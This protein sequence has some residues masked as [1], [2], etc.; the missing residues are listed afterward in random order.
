MND[1]YVNKTKTARH[2]ILSYVIAVGGFVI[3]LFFG[4]FFV[5]TLYI[6]KQFSL[7]TIAMLAL[8]LLICGVGV[9]MF[10]FALKTLRLLRSINVYGKLLIPDRPI[11]ISRLSL[12]RKIEEE[13]IKD[14]LEELIAR[15]YITGY[16]STDGTQVTLSSKNIQ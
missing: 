15:E 14:Q 12:M 9:F 6:S 13:K 3:T 7:S 8:F 16:F 5:A 4:F 2:R 10:I 1:I 11:Q